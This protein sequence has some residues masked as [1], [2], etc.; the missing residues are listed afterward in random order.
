MFQSG[1]GYLIPPNF[2]D[3][4]LVLCLKFLKSVNGAANFFVLDQLTS[5]LVTASVNAAF[6]LLG[7]TAYTMIYR[8]T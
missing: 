4:F 2:A 1:K 7:T 6:Q 8:G 5:V 3:W